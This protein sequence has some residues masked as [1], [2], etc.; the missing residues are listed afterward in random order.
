M[1]AGLE[2]T[3]SGQLMI[4]GPPRSIDIDPKDR[5]IAMVFQN[6]ALYPHMTVSDN[7]GF[8]LKLAK[9]VPRRPKRFSDANAVVGELPVVAADFGQKVTGQRLATPPR[10]RSSPSSTAAV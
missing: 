1:V 7:I 8:A 2:T 4:R 6:Y 10:T 9:E 5:H 3:T